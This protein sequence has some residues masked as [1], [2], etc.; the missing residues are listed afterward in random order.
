LR[1]QHPRRV[2][3]E[4]RRHVERGRAPHLR[5][6]PV[7][8]RQSLGDPRGLVAVRAKDRFWARRIPDECYQQMRAFA[9]TLL[10]DHVN[11]HPDG[12]FSIISNTAKPA[13]PSDPLRDFEG[14][15]FKDGNDWKDIWER[16]AFYKVP[17]V[18]IAVVI[19][20]H[21]AWATSYGPVE[22]NSADWIHNDTVFQA[23]SCSK[24]ISSIG[25]LR[26]RPG[27]PLRPADYVN[28]DTGG[29]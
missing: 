20:N 14:R 28:P 26:L 1:P 9:A 13:Y 11:F 25:F 3:P 17:G 15:I 12:G 5:G 10:V 4:A 16:M 2:L 23:A 29:G 27:G 24:P 19:D 21:V 6:I 18:G 7:P 8:G 22:K